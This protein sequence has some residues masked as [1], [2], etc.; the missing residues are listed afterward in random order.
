MEPMVPATSGVFRRRLLPLANTRLTTTS[1]QCAITGCWRPDLNDGRFL[2]YL[3][4][5][6]QERRYRPA[7]L[8]WANLRERNFGANPLIDQNGQLMISSRPGPEI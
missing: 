2:P 1:M 4:L 8:R 5:L 3:H 7:R 6:K